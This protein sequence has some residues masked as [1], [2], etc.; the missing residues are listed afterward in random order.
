MSIIKTAAQ[1]AIELGQKSS[2]I[3]IEK[4]KE[5]IRP[6]YCATK[7]GTP[8]HEGSCVLLAFEGKHFL[9][10]AAHIIDVNKSEDTRIYVGGADI[11]LEITGTYIVTPLIDG[12]RSKDAFDFAV[13]QLSDADIQGLGNVHYIAQNDIAPNRSTHEGR[14]Y[15]IMGYPNKKNDSVDNENYAVISSRWHYFSTFEYSAELCKQLKIEGEHHIFVGY[16]RKRSK[17]FEGNII[18]SISLKGISGGAVF[19]LGDFG[20][21]GNYAMSIKFNPLLAGIFIEAHPAYHTT[22]ATKISVIIEYIKAYY[23]ETP[24]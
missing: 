16:H 19:D 15:A 23:F 22:V 9:I 3:A 5:A 7:K 1:F 13:L 18:N 24:Q 17:D 8:V 6:I 2:E 11:L 21:P 20:V 14:L 10:T 12:V 4:Y